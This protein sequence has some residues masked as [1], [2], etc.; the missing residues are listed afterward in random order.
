MP[1]NTIIQIRKGTASEWSTSNPVLA[2]GEPGYDLTNQIFKIGDGVNGW[3]NLSSLNNK[4]V[5]GSFVLNSPSGTFN[6]DEGYSVGSLDV[7]LNG[8]KLS[9]SGDFVANDGL[10]F[11]LNE[12]AISGSVIEYL[13]LSAGSNFSF[14]DYN[15][16]VNSVSG[17]LPVTNIIG[18]TNVSVVPSGSEYSISLE[19]N[20]AI[21]KITFN[22]FNENLINITSS[23][24]DI[25]LDIS[26]GTVQKYTLI[27]NTNFILP[28]GESGQ[29]FTLFVNTG[30][31][32]Y[33]ASFNS[34]RWPDSDTPVISI[35]PEVVDIFSFIYDGVDWYGNYSQKY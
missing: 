18:G 5:R 32:N 11:T 12:P 14:L 24:S 8:I 17:I 6:V 15:H 29:S 9:S 4:S 25:N 19:N 35:E 33:T 10:T 2:S 26:A 21:N 20:I 31:G 1:A 30:S 13:G 22:S 23:V 3:N 27:N 7:F 16:F 28:S 34:A